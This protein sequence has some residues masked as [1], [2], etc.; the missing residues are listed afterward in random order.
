MR[1]KIIVAATLTALFAQTAHSQSRAIS[2]AEQKI[3]ASSYGRVLKDPASAQYRW[4]MLP[5][6]ATLKGGEI[7]YCFQV[8]AKNSYGAFT[9]FRSILG[10]VS[11]VGG[12]ITRFEYVTGTLDDS[13]ELA[14]ATVNICRAYG[15]VF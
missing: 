1:A 5:T 11:Q 14:Q 2:R 15:V 8:N 3:I 10:T 4:P 6:E 9:G 7:A 13:P 12:K